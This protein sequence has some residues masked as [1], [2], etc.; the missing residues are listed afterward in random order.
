MIESLRHK[1]LKRLFVNGDRS[2]LPPDMVERIEDILALLDA[3]SNIRDMDRPSL[4]LHQLEGDLMGF[5]AVTVRANW[6]IVFRFDGE[7]ASD[8]DFLDYH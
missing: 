8:V 4:R 7:N 2:K 5:W 6:R 1:G 3:A